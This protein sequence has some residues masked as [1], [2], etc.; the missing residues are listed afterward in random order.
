MATKLEKSDPNDKEKQ[1]YLVLVTIIHKTY[2][3]AVN[4][5]GARRQTRTNNEKRNDH[6]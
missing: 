2:G 1:V 5:D 4:E 6:S 3:T